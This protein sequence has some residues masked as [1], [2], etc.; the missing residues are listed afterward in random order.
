VPTEVGG[1]AVSFDQAYGV[2]ELH[3]KI[4]RLEA[5]NAGLRALNVELLRQLGA[6]QLSPRNSPLDP[7]NQVPDFSRQS[8]LA[9]LWDRLAFWRSR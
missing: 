4:E 8:R 2:N 1:G 3:E 7:S 6:W 5:E 9:R